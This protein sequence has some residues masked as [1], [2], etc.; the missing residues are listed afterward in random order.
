MTTNKNKANEIA[1]KN[2]E[3][4]IKLYQKY[5]NK[6]TIF[7]FKYIQNMEDAKDITQDMFMDL[8]RLIREKFD[9]QDEKKF[10]NWLYKIAKRKAF[11]FLKR[12]KQIE[13]IK[14]NMIYEENAAK[15]KL[16]LMDLKEILNEEEFNLLMKHILFGFTFKEMATQNKMSINQ[17]KKLY[18]KIIQKIIQK[19][20]N[21][22]LFSFIN[23]LEDE[24]KKNK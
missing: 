24:R 13:E 17:I 14:N 7:I 4:F 2:E 5:F 16:L 1:N 20:K 3:I 19:N 22:E 15:D 23:R 9:Y 6:L 8:P 12:K 18:K 11:D 10:N 21:M